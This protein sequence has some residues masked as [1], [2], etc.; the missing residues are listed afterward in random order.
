MNAVRELRP[1]GGLGL[2]ERGREVERD[3]HHLAGRAHL[4]AEQRVRAGEAIERQHDLLDADVAIAR[5]GW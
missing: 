2:R 4:G 3:P 5:V 1:R